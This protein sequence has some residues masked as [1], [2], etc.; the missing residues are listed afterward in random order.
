MLNRDLT[1][2]FGEPQ[3]SLAR[4]FYARYERKLAKKMAVNR[5]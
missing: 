4:S 3:S 5:S 2:R 1:S